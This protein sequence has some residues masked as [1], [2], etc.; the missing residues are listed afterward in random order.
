M[1]TSGQL[2]ENTLSSP[3]LGNIEE[4]ERL[5][6]E[7][8]RREEKEFKPREDAF[9]TISPAHILQTLKDN[10]DGDARL[11]IRV[12]R[13]RYCFDENPSVIRVLKQGL[14][15]T[16]FPDATK[17]FYHSHFPRCSHNIFAFGT[18]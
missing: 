15:G 14:R 6:E 7:E 16:A 18:P 13:N 8:I 11:F 2:N 1:I 5:V 12:M 3:Y 4:I 17:G 9:Q 10:Q